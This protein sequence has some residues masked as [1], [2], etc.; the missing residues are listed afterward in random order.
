MDATEWGH[1]VERLRA[2]ETFQNVMQE[3]RDD[4]VSQFLTSGPG[5]TEA[6]EQAHALIRALDAIDGKLSS[7]SF[8]KKLAEKGQHRGND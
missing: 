5:D 3:C 6:R 8:G 2:D 7:G 1:R 4:A